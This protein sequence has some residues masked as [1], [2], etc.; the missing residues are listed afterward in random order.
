MDKMGRPRTAAPQTPE[1]VKR[2][3]AQRAYYRRRAEDAKAYKKQLQ[4]E[5]D[6]VYDLWRK[7]ML[8][9]VDKQQDQ[10]V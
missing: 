5:K 1:E 8:V 7:G 3:E 4:E 9:R 10:K 6:E 2:I